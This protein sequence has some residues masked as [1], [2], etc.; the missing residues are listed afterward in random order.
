VDSIEILYRIHLR[1]FEGLVI[2]LVVATLVSVAWLACL[3]H[4]VG[5]VV[6]DVDD[7]TVTCCPSLV[8]APDGELL[9]AYGTVAG[10]MLAT[11]DGGSWS[12]DPVMESGPLEGQFSV[13]AAA[14]AT[15]DAGGVHIAS[16]SHWT[17]VEP[18]GENRLIHSVRT[19]SGWENTIVDED[20][21]SK[22]VSV[23]VDSD[24]KA[25]IS[26]S[27]YSDWWYG[28][29]NL[30]YAT[31]STGEW[32]AYDI[33]SQHRYLMWDE[34][35]ASV[36][37]VD[38]TGRP[39]IACSSDYKAGYITNLT[40]SS[41]LEVVSWGNA[42]YINIYPS[43]PSIW[44][45]A[46]DVVHVLCVGEA[47]EVYDGPVSR[48]VVHYTVDGGVGSYQNTTISSGTDFSL[49]ATQA[50]SGP[51]GE[52]RI[53]YKGSY[54]IG[55][56]K[57]GD[58]GTVSEESVLDMADADW[59][60]RSLWRDGLSVVLRGDNG[61]VIISKPYGS[62]G[63]VTDS[64]TFSERMSA[65]ITP[66]QQTAIFIPPVIIVISVSVVLSKR[67]LSK[68]RMWREAVKE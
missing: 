15:D 9:V 23:A 55:L 46:D 40:G 7:A 63:Y 60:V 32:V 26:Y 47:Q 36:I 16:V 4:G 31:D 3:V 58:D 65:A 5:W 45:E 33:S 13:L 57:L 52:L 17:E 29:R 18:F 34:Y 2:L 59:E 61:E 51:D 64:F 68:S 38:S 24:S 1:V 20:V 25:H 30:T 22:S 35:I 43:R 19:T 41:E 66:V 42:A 56:L 6:R 50:V 21:S 14:I 49:Y 48:T 44:V 8:E 11:M 10:L 53:F 62:F 27:V 67:S 37:C 39:H 12:I 54:S 28:V